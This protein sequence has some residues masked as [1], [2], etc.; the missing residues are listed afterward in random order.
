MHLQHGLGCERPPPVGGMKHPV[1]ECLQVLCT[2]PPD[3]E[4]SDGGED[5]TFDLP[6][7][8][9]PGGMCQRELLAGK[10]TVS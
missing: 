8:A 4:M 3:P 7:I 9:I 6:P 1:I 2:K 10:P 5:V